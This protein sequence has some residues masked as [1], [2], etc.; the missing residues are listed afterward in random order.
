MNY[1]KDNPTGVDVPIK[2]IQKRMYDTLVSLWQVSNYDAYGRVYKNMKLERKMPEHYIG[3][4]EYKEVLLDDTKD[5]ISFFSIH[6][7]ASVNGNILN[8]GCDIVFSINLKA[9]SSNTDRTDA[10]VQRDVFNVLN[11]FNGV[12]NIATIEIGLT[13][14][15]SDYRGVSE[16]F[17]DMQDYHHF[18]IKGNIN[19]TNNNC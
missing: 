2:R 8:T 6:D 1:L 14:V 16:H 13:N 5:A 15:Y 10:E 18:K 12:F 19:Y 3:E 11:R 9:A 7:S 17:K 4:G